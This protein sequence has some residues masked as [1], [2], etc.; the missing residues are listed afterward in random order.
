M[1]GP[2]VLALQHPGEQPVGSIASCGGKDK[3]THDLCQHQQDA[4]SATGHAA[5]QGQGDQTQH[6]VDEGGGQDGIARLGLQL[7]HLL[8]CFNSD[9]DGGGGED[10]A[11]KYVLQETAAFDHSRFG[12]APG[13]SRAHGQRDQ[14]AQQG[15]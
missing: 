13:Q 11:H 14:Y 15:H 7:S 4:F 5:D 9:A 10:R 6:I 12:S 8:Q 2:A 3:E 1:G